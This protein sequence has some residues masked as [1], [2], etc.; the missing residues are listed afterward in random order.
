MKVILSA[1][2][3]CEIFI[4]LVPVLVNVAFITLLERKILGYIQLRKGPNK[5]R[6]IGVLQPFGDA[7]KLFI[8]E[9]TVPYVARSMLYILSPS[10]ILVLMLIIWCTAPFQELSYLSRFRVLLFIIFLRLNVYP[11]F[12]S[13]WAS[14]SK[15]GIVGAVRG[16]AQAVSYEISLAVIILAVMVVSIRIIIHLVGNFGML[17]LMVVF[18]PS[19]GL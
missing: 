7:I 19:I 15:Y 14:N 6:V 12:L 3:V 4:L 1:I 9:V 11:L 5:V 2:A 10:L 8:K 13:G 16:I 17:C 18:L